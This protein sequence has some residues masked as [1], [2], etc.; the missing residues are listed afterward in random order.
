MNKNCTG[1]MKI[2]F[3]EAARLAGF[4]Y[5]LFTIDHE[6]TK[7]NGSVTQWLQK[8]G[9]GYD[10]VLSSIADIQERRELGFL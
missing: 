6:P 10:V 5:D 9:A 3:D 4:T 8:Y 7:W 2:A 1:Y